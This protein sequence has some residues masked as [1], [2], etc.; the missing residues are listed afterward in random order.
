MAT[1]NE[2]KVA[3]QRSRNLHVKINILNFNLQTVDE[4][5]GVALD[6]ANFTIDA[7]SDI[8][9]TCSISIVPI[10]SSYNIEFGSNIWID[11][12]VKIYVGIEDISNNNEIVYTNMGIYLINNPNRTYDAINNVLTI[13]GLDIMS[14]LTGLRNGY[15]EGI[16]YQIKKNTSIKNS[17]ISAIA[18]GGFKKY[19]I[20]TPSPTSVTPNAISISI[21]GTV[22]DLVSQLRDINASYQT[23]FD[24]N[25]KFIFNLIPSGKNEQIMVDDTIWSKNL[26][27]YSTD[28]S[29]ENV[30]NS[31]EVFGKTQS[32]GITPYGKSEDTNPS[33]PFYI[34]GSA[35][36]IRMV[37][38]GG[39]YD[40]ISSNSLAQQRANYE[41]YLRCKLQDQI[42]I[43]CVPIYWLDVN[44][45]VEITLPNKQGTP[46]KDKYIIK[47]ID[48]NVGINGT[49]SITLMKYYPL[50]P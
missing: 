50:Y 28:I 33:S 13:N 3:K 2:I 45:V 35:G 14:K 46:I 9:R 32:N 18:L 22:F 7:T 31:I 12:Y 1:S 38:S 24:V 23:F 41:L 37:L 5:S 27:S 43:Q 48:T 29:F 4:I 44:W 25:G 15:L 19:S 42:Q 8:R 49:Q 21:G 34:N 39:E 47:R 36:K 11:K 30:K 10:S 40:N 26:I 17:M 20:A 6:G 16:E